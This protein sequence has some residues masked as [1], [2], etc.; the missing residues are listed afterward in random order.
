M[1][2]NINPDSGLPEKTPSTVEMKKMRLQWG[3]TPVTILLISLQC[4]SGALLSCLDSNSPGSPTYY[5]ST[6]GS[7]SLDG[8]TPS[9]PWKTVSKI[10]STLFSPGDSI[11]FKRGETW[12][13]QLIIPSSGEAGNPITFGAYG[14]GPRPRIA[15]AVNVVPHRNAIRNANFEDFYGTANDGLE[16]TLLHFNSAGGSVEAVSDTPPVGGGDVAVKL[17]SDGSSANLYWYV[18]L[19]AEMNVKLSWKAKSIKGDGVVAIRNQLHGV[20]KYYLQQDLKTW[21][22][23][24]N[25]NIYPLSGSV[26][27]QWTSR[28]MTFWTDSV[29]GVY[30]IYFISGD[31]SGGG[32]TTW[33]DD[34]SLTVQW[35]PYSGNTYQLGTGYEPR[36]VLIKSGD[37]WSISLNAKDFGRDKDTLYNLEWVYDRSTGLIYFRDD[38]GSPNNSGIIM[39]I[40]V[41]ETGNR[42]ESGIYFDQDYVFIDNLAVMGWPD[43]DPTFA[44]VGGIAI[45]DKTDN[46]SITNC[47]VGFNYRLGVYA[48]SDNSTFSNNTFAYNGGSGFVMYGTARGNTISY[49]EAKFNGYW[50]LAS[51]DGEGIALGGN[52]SNNL[53]EWN[54]IHHNNRHP[55]SW[56]HGGLVIYH[57]NDN[58]IR[59]NV[60]YLNYKA[61]VVLDGAGNEFYYNLVFNNG[62]GYAETNA[63]GMC[64]LH[65]RNYS[66][67]GEGGNK[68]VNNI[69]YGGTSDTRW[70]GNLFINRK[71]TETEVRN[72]VFWGF[73]NDGF[74]NVQ[75]RIDGGLELT[76]T[77]FSNNVIGPQ[78]TGIIHYSGV[79]YNTLEDYQNGTGQGADSLSDHPVF[80]D[81][82]IG[83][84]HPHISSP[85]VD[86]G[87]AAGFNKDFEGNPING[88][89]DIGAFE[90]VDIN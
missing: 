16:D 80:I 90:F 85:L 69:F 53:I 61:G 86:A 6:V 24:E 52:T 81:S 45:I 4:L 23:F 28:S 57:S 68:V 42:G 50:G 71:C 19:P 60:V 36:R 5:V 35:E 15:G 1:N 66:P 49:N 77:V 73:I 62:I 30:Q 72:N 12:R 59:Y 87:I 2:K 39:E 64:N 33:V 34:L 3:A 21:S 63:Y 58:I 74:N 40:S 51:D 70:M 41:P 20:T 83:D 75:I 18:Y 27:G 13:E 43:D 46:I 9:T 56:N 55:D 25:W 65:L 54:D 14:E 48:N 88:L 76:G 37:E 11:L 47:F 44:H 84:F 26:D 8:L 89:P 31:S 67:D 82:S 29:A 32:D 7:D 10:N 78:G 79:N 22:N 17:A 38:T